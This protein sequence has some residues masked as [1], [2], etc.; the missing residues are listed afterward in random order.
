VRVS[1]LDFRQ[2]GRLIE[3][4]YEAARVFLNELKISGPGLYGSP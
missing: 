2:T 4:A 3:T 1:P